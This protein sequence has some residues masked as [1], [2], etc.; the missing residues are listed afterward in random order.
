MH[1]TSTTATT[2]SVGKHMRMRALK[3]VPLAI[4]MQRQ[5]GELTGDPQ[6]CCPA[7]RLDSLY[8]GP[9]RFVDHACL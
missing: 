1:A 9:M 3:P 6:Q 2:I 7:T 4:R 5:I 8:T